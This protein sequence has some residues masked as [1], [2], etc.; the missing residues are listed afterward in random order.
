M[1]DRRTIGEILTSVGRISEADVGT[2][3]EYQREHGGYFGEALLACGLITQEELD[4]GLASQFDLPYVFP[5]ADSVDPAAAALV[6]PEWALSQMTLPIL[7]TETSL[8]VIVD[9]PTKR[10]S[11]RELAEQTGLEV[12][13]ALASPSTIRDLIRQVYA[14]ATAAEE[15][16]QNPVEL[17]EVLDAV[18][19]IE[20][21]RFGISVRGV[22]AYGWWD[23]QGTIRRRALS[24]DWRAA[25]DRTLVPGPGLVPTET[26]RSG[27]AA[28]ITRSGVVMPVHVD[29]I[30]DESGREYLFKPSRA[31]TKL[32]DRFP[33]P[34]DGVVS[35][36]RLLARSGT[37]RF[38]VVAEPSDLGHEIL[39]HLPTLLL[40]PSWRSIY[41]SATERSG[42][43]EA[44]S[45]QM[46]EEPATWAEELDALRAF[47][48]DVVT[49]DLS[50]GDQTWAESA[51]DVASV[52]FLLWSD[53][54]DVRPAIAAG[55]RWKLSITKDDEGALAWSLEPLNA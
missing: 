14:R 1:S 32:E 18:L 50:G 24:G 38:I 23:D 13:V 27:W 43:R 22:R 48:F 25:L 31:P 29:Y 54:E 5:D 51:L 44:F 8:R 36:V 9:S 33:P 2:A 19:L 34:S 47:H 35:E 7:R 46:P 39:P 30:A 52:A 41:I 28:E 20:S 45:L 49:V 17:H 10:E 21:P 26:T 53:A 12:E 15:D 16:H 3:L 55:I 4:W 6:S 37:A 40:D 11:V 42:V